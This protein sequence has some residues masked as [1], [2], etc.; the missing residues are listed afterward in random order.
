MMICYLLNLRVSTLDLVTRALQWLDI[1]SGCNIIILTLSIALISVC[2]AVC[3]QHGTGTSC[4]AWVAVFQ[5]S[6]C[7]CQEGYRNWSFSPS[8]KV[9]CLNGN[10]KGFI[11]RTFSWVTS[12]F[13]LV[14]CYCCYSWSGLVCLRTLV[15]IGS[16]SGGHVV[17][18]F[19]PHEAFAIGGTN[20]VRGYEEGAVGS[21]RSYAVGSG[22]ISFPMVS[23][24]SFLFFWSL[25]WF[26]YCRSKWSAFSFA[27]CSWCF[28]IQI[29]SKLPY[30]REIEK[31]QIVAQS[32]EKQVRKKSRKLK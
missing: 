26:A 24:T 30:L 3:S 15:F 7:S 5:Q 17:G 9:W 19:P 18:N 25:L 27:T 14:P 10:L 13:L 23:G 28:T 16:L 12:F 21:G 20:S 32:K 4:F 29:L 8:L 22:E 31:V 1:Y 6:E 2:L 11:V